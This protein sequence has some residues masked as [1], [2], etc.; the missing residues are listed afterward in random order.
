[1]WGRI[2]VW[3]NKWFKKTETD[4]ILCKVWAEAKTIFGEQN[5]TIKHDRNLI[6]W[7]MEKT[8]SNNNRA[9]VPK[10]LHPTEISSLFLLQNIL[11]FHNIG[12]FIF[13]D[14]SRITWKSLLPFTSYELQYITLA[15]TLPTIYQLRITIQCTSMSPPPIYQSRIAIQRPRILRHNALVRSKLGYMLQ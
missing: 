11:L 2:L 8:Y 15:V 10:V 9:K 1:M 12:I 3:R 13:T 4:F 6:T 14:L 5:V 7:A